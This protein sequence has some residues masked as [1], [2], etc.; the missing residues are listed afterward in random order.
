MATEHTRIP[1]APAGVR[2]R[3]IEPASS[4]KVSKTWNDA[5]RRWRQGL[6]TP[7]HMELLRRHLAVTDVEGH[8]P[9]DL[10]WLT[11][12]LDPECPLSDDF[13]RRTHIGQMMGAISGVD[14][15]SA[16]GNDEELQAAMTFACYKAIELSDTPSW[17]RLTSSLAYS[18]LGT[19]LK[20]VFPSDVQLPFPSFYVELPPDIFTLWH[21]STGW[22]RVT[23]MSIS[24]G[25]VRKID[26]PG[27]HQRE[28]GRRL[29]VV[30]HCD[31]N[32]NSTNA[33][34]DNMLFMSFPLY[35]D[36][37][38]LEALVLEERERDGDHPTMASIG[39]TFNGERRT[40]GE[41][42]TLFRVLAVNFLVYLSC[43]NVEITHVHAA[44]VKK[45][46]SKPTSKKRRAQIQR[47]ESI[48][49]WV[50]GSEVTVDPSLRRAVVQERSDTSRRVPTDVLVS[51]YYRRQ[52]TGPKSPEHPKG[53]G[54]YNCRIAPTV[55][56]PSKDGTV[57]GHE[58][59]VENNG[60]A[61]GPILP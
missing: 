30:M 6:P 41:L 37:R 61:P 20:G 48:P 21:R 18:L 16:T 35:D 15:G 54:W 49:E 11:D 57:R 5:T 40:N 2:T 8:I 50:V 24:E 60:K 3:Y 42:R 23:A 13:Y 9:V 27:F 51:G 17:Y 43:R 46:R 36:T 12:L 19:T 4:R 10:Q 52:W 33:G 59:K 1:A 26:R 14:I 45:L 39:G 7:R 28:K 58:Y 29:L 38:E 31:A 53:T 55:R 47:L 34:D 56:N 32:E 22:H 44:Q 25:Y